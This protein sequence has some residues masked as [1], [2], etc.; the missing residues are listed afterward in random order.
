MF[1][2][3]CLNQLRIVLLVSSVHSAPKYP[4]PLLYGPAVSLTHLLCLTSEETLSADA[5]ASERPHL[6]P[7]IPPHCYDGGRNPKCKRGGS[8]MAAGHCIRSG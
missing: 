5:R 4:R 3:E 2:P 6:S 1:L 7:S 8:T